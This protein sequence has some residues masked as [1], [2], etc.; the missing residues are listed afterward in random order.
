MALRYLIFLFIITT[1]VHYTY[2]QQITVDNT[3]SP[4]DLIQNTLIQGCVEV[5]NISSPL[6]GNP[7][8]LGSFGYFD[9]GAS[10]FPFQN[11]I[12]L[13]TGNANSG[14]NG[15]NT[16]VLNDGDAAW[17]SDIDLENAL[18]VS[19]TLNTTS[20]QFDFISISNQIQ[21]NY[22]FASEE[23][24]VTNPCSLNTDGF[25]FLIRE[26]GSG[27]TYTNIALIPGTSEP[28]KVQ[29]IRDE[30]FGF[31]EASNE[32]YFDG[33][34]TGDT[35]YN[36]R[37]TVLSATATIQPYVQYQIKLVIADQTD[38]R[39]DSAVFIE[40][41]SFNSTVDLGVDFSTCASNVLLEGNI[42]NPNATYSWFYNDGLITSANQSTFNAPQTG[43]YRVE[44]MIPFGNSSCTIEDDINITLSSTQSSDPIPD[45]DLCDDPSNDGFE[46]FDLSTKDAEV[47]EVIASLPPSSYTFSYHE[48]YTKAFNNI[49][50][51]TGP[52]TSNSQTV[53]VRIEATNGCLAISPMSL[54]V[55]QPPTIVVPADF[56][57][58]DDGLADGFTTMDLNALLDDEITNGQTDLVV[59][60][61]SSASDATNTASALPMPNTFTNQ[62]VYVSV[63]N[64]LTGCNTTTALN[65]TITESAVIN[66]ADH[67]IDACDTDDDGFALFDLTSIIPDIIGGLTNVSI[68]FHQTPDDALSGSDP[69]ADETNYPNNIAE[70]EIV[71]I[72]VENNTTGCASIAPIELH[73]NLLLTATNIEDVTVCDI[74][75]DDIEEFD[76]EAI[77]L[78]I[79]NN[80]PDITV[81]F[82]ETEAD[83]TSL[84]PIDPS[85]PYN[86]ISKIIYLALESPTCSDEAEIELILA[87][88]I[89]FTS[90]ATTRCD[91]DQ[92]RILTIDLSTFDDDVT[93][94][95]PGFSVSYFLSETD[96]NA[97]PDTPLPNTYINTTP[98]FTLF[99]RI[100]FDASGCSSI[101]SFQVEV[102]P[103]PLSE[104]PEDI[105]ICDADRDAFS[106]INLNNSIPSSISDTPNRT[107]TFHNS[108]DDANSGTA[109]ISNIANYNAQTEIVYMRVKNDLTPCYSVEELSIIV[110]TLP[111]IVNLSNLIDSY[112]F[113]ED[114]TDGFGEF[115]FETR[116]TEALDGQTGKDVSYYINS[117]DAEN[118][119]NAIDKTSVFVNTNNPQEI[120]VRIENITDESCYATSSF[121]IEVGT[122][123][124]YNDPADL[125]VCDDISND[126]FAFFDLTTNITRVSEGISDIENVTFYESLE[127]ARN[128]TNALPLQ[129]ISTDNPQTI[130]V[131]IDNGTLC[132]SI[133]PFTLNAIP[134][135]EVTPINPIEKCDDNADGFA[136]FDL[137]I[138][139]LNILNIRQ[140]NL[141]VA[142]YLTLADSE[143]LNGVA[144]ANPENFTNTSNPQTVYIK[145]FNT[146]STCSASYPIDLIVNQ[147]PIINDFTTYNV[148]NDGTGTV[149]LTDINQIVTDVNFNVLFTYFSDETDAI[150]NTNALDTNY[151]YITTND[152]LF[153]R[154]EYSTTNCS[155]YYEFNLAINPL[156]IANQPGDLIACDDDFDGL[157]EF[158][159][160][161]QDS[162]ILSSQNPSLFAI[163]YHNS[164]LQANENNSALETDYMAFDSEIIYARIE[165]NITGCYSVIQFSVVVNPL[166]LVSIEDQV[167]C[168]DNL[169]LLVSVNTNNP[170]DQYLWSTGETSPEIE[171][172][173]TGSYTVSIT[174]NFG[175][176]SNSIFNV[177]ESESAI[178]DLIETVDFSDPNNITVT[179]NGIGD[180]LFQLNNRNFQTSNVFQNVPLGYNTITI[181]DQNGCAQVTRDVLVIDTPKHMTPND[182]GDFDTWHIV[183]VETLPGTTINIF[184]R[185]GK[186]LKQINANTS[187]WDGTYN[188]NKMPT[189]DY[190]YAANVIQNGK[191]F[192]V[193]GHFTLKR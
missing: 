29:T 83:R 174:N 101:S 86:S 42:D 123:P 153:V 125:F 156:P 68:S 9:R 85:I 97:N 120:F 24:F 45:Y 119:E 2:A 182:D 92:D 17:G 90:F 115:I 87:P 124:E 89:N 178:I 62:P 66:T 25:A 13:S 107:V 108:L 117:D 53:Y 55:F 52:I 102:L 176:A 134:V 75:N 28:I 19:G 133:A 88:I 79:I 167:I 188:D 11:G 80:I 157:L 170:T 3:V 26:A 78:S 35:N 137:T 98:I 10:N 16:D 143:S 18:G 159:L 61:H 116:D 163:T 141:V 184:D 58:C 185:F 171:I 50:P 149:D 51:I 145:V 187:G 192:E 67:Y 144:I 175:C 193:K 177:T 130:Y 91:D 34:N 131:Q 161:Q 105:I 103:A 7:T 48:G 180:Y 160:L 30:I 22:I 49:E 41:N 181:I 154:A 126:G 168:L 72:R 33:Y 77:A 186:L 151:S 74:D 109:P 127:D 121:F 139:E 165:N 46:T 84:N 38:E 15:Q 40:G 5:S 96:A 140:E 147:P 146:V 76:L 36:G 129:Y 31:C 112:I 148:C 47:L 39:F 63:T 54:N 73:T 65:I 164:S 104:K 191:T 71:F 57:I 20:I 189:G 190:W 21:F 172:F 132:N 111:Y 106:L 150:A 113:C 43:N 1:S 93:G 136:A 99:P 110:N 12:V 95:Q 100:N 27:S 142:Y 114:E 135:P 122:N 69:I 6:N 4:Q 81:E 60:Y 94:G 59:T 32:Q 155:D 173:E 23:Y 128:S 64:P 70:V 138:A 183:G 56:E 152:T 14:G 82:Y 169:P 37:T 158:N 8:G 118:K 179:I 44:I 166:P 162:S